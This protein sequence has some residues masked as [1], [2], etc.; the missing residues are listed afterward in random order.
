MGGGGGG[1][2]HLFGPGHFNINFYCYQSG[3]LLQLGYLLKYGITKMKT[4]S[5]T[6]I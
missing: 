1:G 3:H 6:I 5:H 4:H 2:G